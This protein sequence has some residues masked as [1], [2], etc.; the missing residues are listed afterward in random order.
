MTERALGRTLQQW[1]RRCR[2]LYEVCSTGNRGTPER[3]VWPHERRAKASSLE[4]DARRGA[5]LRRVSFQDCDIGVEVA[6]RSLRE[7][8]SEGFPGHPADGLIIT[9]SLADDGRCDNMK[10]HTDKRF[11]VPS[12]Y[13]RHQRQ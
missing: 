9:I 3:R 13:L 6:Q 5:R 8:R 11:G 10:R 7:L 12:I 1:R 2:L 4:D